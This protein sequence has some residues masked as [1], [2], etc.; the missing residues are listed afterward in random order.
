MFIRIREDNRLE[1]LR[2]LEF[3]YGTEW[4]AEY[5]D[6][7]IYVQDEDDHIIMSEEVYTY[8]TE[9][10]KEYNEILELRRA[11]DD[12][13]LYHDLVEEVAGFGDVEDTQRLL[14]ESLREALG[15]PK[16]RYVV[17]TLYPEDKRYR[18]GFNDE[19]IEIATDDLEE[20]KKVARFHLYAQSRLKPSERMEIEI[21]R[22]DGLNYDI[23]EKHW[24]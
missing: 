14:I 1:E 19:W 13:E 9:R 3:D 22:Q 20:A 4:T 21:R 7:G 5:I 23:I 10:A 11:L 8:W 6:A 15:M 17:V 18:D 2:I 12:E 24:Y 16:K